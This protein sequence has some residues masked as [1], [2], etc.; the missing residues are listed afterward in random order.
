MIDLSPSARDPRFGEHLR[1]QSHERNTTVN[2][3]LQGGMIICESVIDYVFVEAAKRVRLA[4][5]SARQGKKW[6]CS[7]IVS[8]AIESR[9]DISVFEYYCR[10][11]DAF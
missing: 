2:D 1:A 10:L 6:Q 5:P 11:K 9:L 8:N 4:K 7:N 3:E